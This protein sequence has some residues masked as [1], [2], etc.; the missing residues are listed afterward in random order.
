[1]NLEQL[2]SF[3]AVARIGHFT[4]AAEQLHLAQPSLS[5]QIATLEH[6][7]GAELFHRV[8][9]HITLTAAGERL[10]PLA[11]RM[12]ADAELARLEMAELADL[13]RG[14]VRLGAT[15]TLC[16]SLVPEV[17]AAFRQKF[18]GI[19]LRIT[20]R[21]SNGLA[22][23]LEEGALDLALMT[24][25]ESIAPSAMSLNRLPLLNEQLVV[26]GAVSDTNLSSRQ[27]ISLEEL[28][29]FPQIAFHRSYDLRQAT[30]AAFRA[31]H[32]APWNAVEGA[33]MDAVLRFVE[34]GIGVAV[35]PAMVLLDRP[36]L[37]SLRLSQ[38]QLSRTISLA[39]RPDFRLSRAALAMQQLIV[40]TIEQ[41]TSVGAPLAEL[42]SKA[43]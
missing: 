24:A 30:D 33:E 36:K 37:H 4:R 35:V 8:R 19:E 41:I 13:R 16:I 42:L 5:R 14:A 38:P 25:T 28:A 7:L 3:D 1:M 31:A 32:L 29:T 20:E 2:R 21:G 23:E 18:P 10:L 11:R 43:D 12:L 26:I 17:L 40:S 22:E 6:D 27:I 9:G 39:H 34:R 15:P